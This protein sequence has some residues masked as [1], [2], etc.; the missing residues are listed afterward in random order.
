MMTQLMEEIKL[1][2]E[3]VQS[4]K[5]RDLTQQGTLNSEEQNSHVCTKSLHSMQFK[6]I[7]KF[8]FNKTRR[9]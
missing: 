9:Y 3:S 8:N 7:T 1:L 2:E 4:N 5:L 6:F